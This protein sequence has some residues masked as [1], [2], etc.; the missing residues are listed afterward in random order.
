MNVLNAFF[1]CFFALSKYSEFLTEKA[2]PFGR[3]KFCNS[4]EFFVFC[5]KEFYIFENHVLGKV[6]HKMVK[7]LQKNFTDLIPPVEI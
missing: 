3:L 6:F 5:K 1:Q 4:G 7:I 2:H